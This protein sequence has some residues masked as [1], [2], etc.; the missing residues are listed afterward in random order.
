MDDQNTI[1]SDEPN[2]QVSAK[3]SDEDAVFQKE[4][5]DI[6]KAREEHEEKKKEQLERIRKE[7]E[8]NKGKVKK[9]NEVEEQRIVAGQ[10]VP[11]KKKTYE[12]KAEL[13]RHK[14][15]N[16]F[17]GRGLTKI[18]KTLKGVHG[19]SVQ[20]KIEFIKALKA[21]NPSKSVLKKDDFVDFARRF[22]S[23]RFVGQR[24][25]N[26]AKEGINIKDMRKRFGKRDIDKLTRGI[27]GEED[28][29]RYKSS[30]SRSKNSSVPPANIRPSR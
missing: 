30:S 4:M 16:N 12:H 19:V 2:N 18:N 7:R 1:H 14:R 26:V 6:E 5:D 13:F 22:K 11:T 20:K 8:K 9:E 15:L 23:K 24:F 21:Y 28:P 3:V 25:K 17:S 10:V 27:T 29:N